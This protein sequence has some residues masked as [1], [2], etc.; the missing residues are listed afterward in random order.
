MD[1]VGGGSGHRME[2]EEEPT[3]GPPEGLTQ[4]PVLLSGSRPGGVGV[5]DTAG[6]CLE[7]KGWQVK[8]CDRV[9]QDM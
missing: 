8:T 1:P 9:V 7:Q 4:Q 2:G 6:K 5:G 3:S